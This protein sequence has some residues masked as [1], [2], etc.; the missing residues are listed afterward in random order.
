ML[1]TIGYSCRMHELRPELWPVSVGLCNGKCLPCEQ[2]R[3]QQDAERGC[4]LREKIW[5]EER[6]LLDVGKF[7]TVPA[8]A[9]HFSTRSIGAQF[10]RQPTRCIRRPF[11]TAGSNLQPVCRRTIF[12]TPPYELQEGSAAGWRTCEEE[13]AKM[14]KNFGCFKKKISKISLADAGLAEFSANACNTLWE[15]RW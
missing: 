2:F 3:V 7:F 9:G 13:N 1:H 10:C 11:C 5:E 14:Y 4:I 15:F 6:E 12:G 8:Y